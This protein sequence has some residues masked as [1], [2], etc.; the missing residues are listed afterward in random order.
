MER[1]NKHPEAYLGEFLG[2]VPDLLQEHPIGGLH[3]EA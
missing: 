1:V 2:E 3:R